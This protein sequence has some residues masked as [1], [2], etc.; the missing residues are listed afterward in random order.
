MNKAAIWILIFGVA[1]LL[2]AGGIWYLRN[3]TTVN[4]PFIGQTSEVK[5]QIYDPP[6]K[7][8]VYGRPNFNS[9][10]TESLEDMMTTLPKNLKP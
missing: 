3:R 5:G 9:T 2:S 1:V 10:T 8:K 6:S 7:Y 4:I